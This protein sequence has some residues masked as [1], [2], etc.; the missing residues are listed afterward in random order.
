MNEKHSLLF[1]K[2]TNARG[3]A[4]P[5]RALCVNMVYS[6]PEK[7]SWSGSWHGIA[8][9]ISHHRHKDDCGAEMPSIYVLWAASGRSEIKEMRT[10]QQPNSP[11]LVPTWT[12]EKPSRW[13]LTKWRH[14]NSPSYCHH[15]MCFS[16]RALRI[17]T[18]CFASAKHLGLYFNPLFKNLDDNSSTVLLLISWVDLSGHLWTK[19]FIM[20]ANTIWLILY[21]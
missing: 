5:G 19:G 18:P 11:N 10:S 15:G 3:K 17:L 1:I 4:I 12:K 13:R 20:W 16:T 6:N 2:N 21:Y 7:C 14:F 8:G 9:K